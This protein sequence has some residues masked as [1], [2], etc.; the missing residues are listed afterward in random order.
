[1]RFLEKLDL[2]KKKLRFTILYLFTYPVIG[3]HFGSITESDPQLI[4]IRK[5]K[6]GIHGWMFKAIYYNIIIDNKNQTFTLLKK[7]K[8]LKTE[9]YTIQE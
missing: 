3:G 5:I 2:K 6:I 8:R 9:L 4:T 7:I 1:M